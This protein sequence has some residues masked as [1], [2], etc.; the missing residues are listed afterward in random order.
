MSRSKANQ[1][2]KFGQLIEY[3]MRNLFLENSYTKCVGESSPRPFFSK[4]QNRA[5]F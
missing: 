2:I 5:Y 1:K 3:I 4:N